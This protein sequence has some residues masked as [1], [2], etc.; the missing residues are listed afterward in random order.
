M[1]LVDMLRG[2]DHRSIGRADEVVDIVLSSPGRFDEVFN[3][4]LSDDSLIR[5][6]CADA[7]E[8]IARER[9]DLLAPFKGR[10]IME[11]SLI[12]QQEVQWHL[13]QMMAYIEYTDEETATVVRILR[14]LLSSKSRIVVVSSLDTLTE[15]ATRDAS[16]RESVI[17]DIENAMENGA[18]SVKSRGKRLLG[19]LSGDN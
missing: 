6:R 14:G 11:V 5:M 8:K 19:R 4:I 1:G 17:K 18:P 10:L 13:V 2:G 7:A 15:L 9:P 16:L 3:G 12:D